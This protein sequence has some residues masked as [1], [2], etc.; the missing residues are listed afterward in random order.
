MFIFDHFS[1]SHTHTHTLSLSLSLSHTVRLFIFVHI[2]LH[3]RSLTLLLLIFCFVLFCFLFFLVIIFFVHVHNTSLKEPQTNFIYI[4]IITRK[5]HKKDDGH[6][7]IWF[8]FIS[9]IS[10]HP[11][12]V[13]FV[14]NPMFYFP[15]SLSYI[16]IILIT[17]LFFLLY[18]SIVSY[19]PF[20][21]CGPF[22]PLV[23]VLNLLH[24]KN[25]R[26]FI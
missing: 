11:T 12:L 17:P 5:R 3:T 1:L 9:Y 4:H 25:T 16:N 24:R 26:T 19:H 14:P 10:S 20:I 2:I 6:I 23:L 13:S 8:F 7:Y 21:F 15:Y 22:L 18:N